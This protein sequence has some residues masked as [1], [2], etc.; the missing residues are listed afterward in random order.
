[1]KKD[2]YMTVLDAFKIMDTMK[3]FYV[4]KFGDLDVI[5]F[6]IITDRQKKLKIRK[7]VMTLQSFSLF[8]ASAEG[9]I[10]HIYAFETKAAYGKYFDQIKKKEAM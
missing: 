7:L 6:D 5:H 2:Y 4:D 9:I 1:M 3:I 8:P 10:G